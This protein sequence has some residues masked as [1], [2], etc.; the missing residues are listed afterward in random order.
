[1]YFSTIFKSEVVATLLV[2]MSNPLLLDQIK[3][4]KISDFTSFKSLLIL[5]TW[6]FAFAIIFSALFDSIG[7]IICFLKG[8]L[9]VILS[10]GLSL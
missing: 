1:M 9:V 10:L 7:M 2:V 8:F 6:V 3:S 5:E 4:T